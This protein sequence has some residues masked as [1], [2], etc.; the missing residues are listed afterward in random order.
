VAFASDGGGDSYA[1]HTGEVTDQ[2]RSE[3]K[4]YQLGRIGGWKELQGQTFAEFVEHNDR[5]T[6]S[7]REAED[8]V[9]LDPSGPIMFYPYPS[10]R[11]LP[12]TR[13]DIARWLAWNNGTVRDL[14]RSIR[15]DGRTDA[16]PVLADALEEAGCTNQDMLNSCRTGD[17]DIDGVWVLGVLLGKEKSPS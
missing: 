5:L 12:F 11:R 17:P 7:W 1:F 9:R 6:R 4:V 8:Q 16:F 15:E 13:K 3:Y 10:R 2:K 14:A